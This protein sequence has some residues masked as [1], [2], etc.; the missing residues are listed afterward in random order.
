M[1]ETGKAINT[2]S[3]THYKTKAKLLREMGRAEESCQVYD[4]AMF[5][6]D[7]LTR[8]EQLGELGEIQVKN[9]VAQLELEKADIITRIRNIAF[10]STILLTFVVIGFTVYLSINLKRTRKLQKSCCAKPKRL[11][12]ANECNQTSSGRCITMYTFLSIT[13]TN[14]LN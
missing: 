1:V 5:L 10:Y 13:S 7:S 11:R 6:A 9:E 4:R 14:R 12:K 3:V 8:K 2:A